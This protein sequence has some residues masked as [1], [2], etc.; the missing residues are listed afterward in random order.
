MHI[1]SNLSEVMIHPKL[2]QIQNKNLKLA[3][4]RD[5]LVQPTSSV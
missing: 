5:F 2:Y 4:I 3:Y 1:Y